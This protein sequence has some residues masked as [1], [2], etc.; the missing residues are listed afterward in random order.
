ME[1]PPG[2]VDPYF[3]QHV[4]KLKKALYGLKQAL[5]AWFQRFSSFL[6]KLGFTCSCVDTSFVLHRQH[7][8]IYLLLYVD[9]IILTGNNNSL[10][11]NFIRQL[12]SEFATK[13]LG[14]LGYFLGLEATSTST[15]LFLSQ[16]K[17]ARDILTRAQLLDCKPVSTPMVVAQHLS[18]VGSPFA[19]ITL[20]RSLVGALQY[21]SSLV[22]IL[23]IM[24]TPLANTCMLPLMN[25]F[26]Q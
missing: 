12:H 3:P 17:Y 4:C 19:D 2:Y 6:L 25:I 5:S 21:L 23:L 11:D 24:S 14:S 8:I 20:Y 1:Q 16:T 10:L 22:L 15:G 9:D 26:K 13:D 7:Q 18:S